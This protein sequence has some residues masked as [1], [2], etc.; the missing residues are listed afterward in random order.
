MVRANKVFISY[1]SQLLERW[2]KLTLMLS[3]S[4]LEILRYLDQRLK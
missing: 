3:L 4:L 1:A 2:L